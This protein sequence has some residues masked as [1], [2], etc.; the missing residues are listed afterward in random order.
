MIYEFV[1]HPIP[2]KGKILMM[3]QVWVWWKINKQLILNTYTVKCISS[4]QHNLM[5]FYKWMEVPIEV[6]KRIKFKTI[7]CLLRRIPQIWFPYETTTP[8]SHF[9]FT[10]NQCSKQQHDKCRK[11]RIIQIGC[12]EWNQYALELLA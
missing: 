9:T 1:W 5:T 10:Y 11:P 2:P 3:C 7:I 4:I 6:N 8:L 12:W